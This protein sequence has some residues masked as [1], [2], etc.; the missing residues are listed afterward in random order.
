MIAV[1]WDNLR[2][3][4]DTRMLVGAGAAVAWLLL[5]AVSPVFSNRPTLMAQ[6]VSWRMLALMVTMSLFVVLSLVSRRG[7]GHVIKSSSARFTVGAAAAFLG[8]LGHGFVEGDLPDVLSATATAFGVVMICLGWARPFAL[9]RLRKR[10][11]GTA[12]G[13]ILGCALYGV[14][15]I[16]PQP[17]SLVFGACLP[18]LSLVCW[19]ALCAAVNPNEIT[20]SGKLLQKDHSCFAPDGGESIHP[21][22]AKLS[23]AI[24]LYSM[25]FVLAGHVLPELEGL[26]VASAI[27]GL[28]NVGAFLLVEVALSVYMVKKLKHEN[29]IAAYRPVTMLVAAAFLLLPF[30]GSPSALV[31]M[32]VA[33]SGFGSFM[34]FLWIVMGNICQKCDLSYSRVFSQGFATLAVGMVLGEFVAWALFLSRQPGFDYVSTLSIVSLFLLV[35]MTWQMSDGSLFANETKEMGGTFGEEE[36]NG[37]SRVPSGM[38]GFVKIAEHYRLSPREIEVLA[39]LVKGRS[40]PYICD[41]LF[42]AKSTVQT[43][44]RH[45]YAKMNITGGRQELIDIIEGGIR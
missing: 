34:V 41:D 6:G 32:A 26:W 7:Q 15:A 4:C 2:E 1:W 27:P 13:S 40:I 21:F 45:I 33:F 22:D 5:L 31:C 18:L 29:P 12:A 9:V 3:S 24:V 39:L 38:S 20:D 11:V 25:L 30:L 23:A 43:H 19:L 8:V 14:V 10:V 16:A 44:V 35:V 17:F 42:V 36:E 37:G 28:L